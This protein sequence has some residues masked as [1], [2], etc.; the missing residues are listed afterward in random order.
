M[1]Q[2]WNKTGKHIVSTTGR[3]VGVVDNIFFSARIP[4]SGEGGDQHIFQQFCQK[5]FFHPY[6]QEPRFLISS[7]FPYFYYRRYF[8]YIFI[9]F[10][11]TFSL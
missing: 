6:F 9:Q 10:K 2:H 3:A 11:I 7:L 5:A 1:D 8:F 4:I